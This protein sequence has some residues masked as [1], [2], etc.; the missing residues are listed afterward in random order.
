MRICSLLPSA[1]E[2]AFAVGAGDD[3][4][5]VSHECDFPDAARA[6]P[7]VTRSSIAAD[8]TGAEIDAQVAAA[9]AAGGSLYGVDAALLARL[10]PDVILT[11]KLCAV[12]AVPSDL[13]DEALHGVPAPPAVVNLEPRSLDGIL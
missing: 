11:Q 7:K 6:L 9:L 3:V 1:T 10:R 12:C 5:G 4:V 8:H 13:V 2:I